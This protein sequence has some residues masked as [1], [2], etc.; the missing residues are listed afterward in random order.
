MESETPIIGSGS[1]SLAVE[2]ATSRTLLQVI[3][4]Q[5]HVF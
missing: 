1:L 2:N 3:V 4:I 5:L